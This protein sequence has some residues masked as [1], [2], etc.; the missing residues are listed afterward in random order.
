[1]S[2]QAQKETLGRR[3]NRGMQHDK[4]NEDHRKKIIRNTK[5]SVKRGEVKFLYLC[6]CHGQGATKVPCEKRA[7]DVRENKFS[8]CSLGTWR[9]SITMKKCKVDRRKPIPN[10]V[11]TNE[12]R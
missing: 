8:E 10:E 12:N 5:T 4:E 2:E 1:M 6:K 11:N 3:P 7:D 9:C